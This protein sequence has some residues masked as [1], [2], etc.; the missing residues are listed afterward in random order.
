LEQISSGEIRIGDRV[1]NELAPKDRDVAMVFQSYALYPHM[2]VRENMSFSLK[3]RG[4]PRAVASSRPCKRGERNSG[5]RICWSA[6]PKICPAA[7]ASASPWAAPWCAPKA[8][9]FDEPLSNLDARLARTDA[10]R[11]PQAAA[12]LGHDLDLRDSRS[13][14]GHDHG[15]SHRR[16]ERGHRAASRHPGELY[17]N[18]ANLFVAGFIGTPAMNFEPTGLGTILHLRIAGQR[19]KVFTTERVTAG[20]EERVGISVNAADVLLFDPGTGLRLSTRSER[21]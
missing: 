4:M 3:L 15:G 8:F 2:T 12:R 9:L 14:R 11:N 21:A 1:V 16:H 20:V 13:D 5:S 7:N 6:S 17:D 18:P 10:L 19:L